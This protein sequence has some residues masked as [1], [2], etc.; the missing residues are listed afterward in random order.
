MVITD[1]PLFW[2]LAR[3]EAYRLR[4]IIQRDGAKSFSTNSMVV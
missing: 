1:E 3:S 4:A 2:R